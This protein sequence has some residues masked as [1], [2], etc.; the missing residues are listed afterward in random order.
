LRIR[1]ATK[2][3]ST[4]PPKTDRALENLGFCV[5]NKMNV[6]APNE[7]TKTSSEIKSRKSSI[8]KTDKTVIN[9]WNT[10]F[11]RYC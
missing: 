2:R 8:E 5:V 4:V 3:P 6:D 9:I 10:Y 1:R 7:A 11:E